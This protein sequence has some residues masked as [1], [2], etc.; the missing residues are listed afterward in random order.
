MEFFKK[1]MI[2]LK[3]KVLHTQKKIIISLEHDS[4][5]IISKFKKNRL[6]SFRGIGS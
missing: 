4:E 2:G 1:I 6:G 5:N 3:Q